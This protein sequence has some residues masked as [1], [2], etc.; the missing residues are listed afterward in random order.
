MVNLTAEKFLGTL[1][2]R[3]CWIIHGRNA[4]LDVGGNVPGSS[5]QVRLSLAVHAHQTHV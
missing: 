5:S 1:A 3:Q 2:I 4:V